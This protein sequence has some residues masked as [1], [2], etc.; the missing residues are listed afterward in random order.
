MEEQKLDTA[1]PKKQ[2]FVGPKTL[3]M[4]FKGIKDPIE[5][6]FP[7]SINFHKAVKAV[8]GEIEEP[9]FSIWDKLNRISFS[10]SSVEALIFPQEQLSLRKSS[11][12]FLYLKLTFDNG[13]AF[14]LTIAGENRLRIVYKQLEELVGKPA[15]DKNVWL[16]IPQ[17]ENKHAHVKFQSTL[18]SIKSYEQVP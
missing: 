4:Y 7:T 14:D 16:V 12:V 3:L 1:K 15:G 6:T 2:S 13:V 11:K 5:V 18:I 8:K 9:V 10:T 17:E